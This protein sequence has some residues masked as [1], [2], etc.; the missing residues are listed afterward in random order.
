MGYM[1][2]A[3]AAYQNTN[4]KTASQGKLIVLLYEGAVKNL[5][6][7]QSCFNP[8]GKVEARN[9]EKFGNFIM[10]AQDI[11]SELQVSLNMER[12][13]QIATNLMSLYVYF[14]QELMS[15][16]ITKDK[17][18]LDFVL[19]QMTQLSEAW[20]QAASSEANAPAGNGSSGL[21]IQG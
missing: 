2:N 15:A 5:T 12:G 13:G 7:A 3:Y 10:K 11:I 18:K 1:N 8:A 4:V 21:N 14:N 17:K 20:A 9:I 16:N 19:N 6:A